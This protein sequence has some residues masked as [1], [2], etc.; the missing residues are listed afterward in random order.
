M[1]K[2]SIDFNHLNPFIEKI[3]DDFQ[4]IEERIDGNSQYHA[5]NQ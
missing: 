5:D 1:H 4:V 3:G 2:R